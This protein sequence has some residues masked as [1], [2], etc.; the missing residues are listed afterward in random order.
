MA[1]PQ[2]PFNMTPQEE[3]EWDKF[4]A[5]RLEEGYPVPGEIMTAEEEA[6]WQEHFGSL[7]SDQD[8]D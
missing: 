2:N 3:A 4:I 7:G 8:E 5:E 1:D 6:A